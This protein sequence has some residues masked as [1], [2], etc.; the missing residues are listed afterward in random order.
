MEKIKLEQMDLF[1]GA[2]TIE[3]IH[4]EKI[5]KLEEQQSNLRK[6]LFRRWQEQEEKIQVLSD[7]ISKVLQLLEA[8]V[9][10][11]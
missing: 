1:D 6:G 4:A 8:E 11:V 2:L 7:S 9:V 10:N 5:R 3:W